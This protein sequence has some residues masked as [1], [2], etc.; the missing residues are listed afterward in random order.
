MLKSF[1]Q[2]GL[3]LVTTLMLNAQTVKLP[4]QKE[5]SSITYSM[6]H[7]LHKWDGVSKEVSSVILTD[8]ERNKITQVAVTVKLATFDSQNANRDSHMLEVA[9]G[10]KFPN[11]TFA[12]NEI[13]QKEDKLL[14]K[15]KLTFHGVTRDLSFEA[16]RKNDGKNIQVSGGFE[17]K[18]T[19]FKVEP[20]SILG[21]A[22]EDFFKVKFLM[23]Y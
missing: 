10:I 14:V 4:N 15:G 6:V 7:P 13:Q 5:K 21:F 2:I 16:I 1:I 12:S 22:T 9:E 18:L 3:M 20:P 17:V 19:D 23:V 11:V 8:Q